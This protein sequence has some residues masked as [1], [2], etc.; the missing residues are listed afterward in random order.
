MMYEPAPSVTLEHFRKL[1]KG[2]EVTFYLAEQGIP[3]FLWTHDRVVGDLI[4]GTIQFENFPEKWPTQAYLYNSGHRVALSVGAF[5]SE[6]DP[7]NKVS[8][9]GNQ[10]VFSSPPLPSQ[11]S[12]LS[13]GLCN[14]KTL[15]NFSNNDLNAID[16]THNRMLESRFSFDADVPSMPLSHSYRRN[17]MKGC[18]D[19]YIHYSGLEAAIAIRKHKPEGFFSRPV[20]TLSFSDLS[21]RSVQPHGWGKDRILI[22]VGSTTIFFDRELKTVDELCQKLVE[23][24]D[25]LIARNR[26]LEKELAQVLSF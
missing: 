7:E 9:V 23:C 20:W 19:F 2:S 15:V 3:S 12:P 16:R 14:P 13:G 22:H 1:S 8:L 4:F 21:N 24:G 17:K 11:T 6:L 5:Y 18:L 25:A 26:G 10:T